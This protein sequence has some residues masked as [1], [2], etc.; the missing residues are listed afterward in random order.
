M[1]VEEGRE[2]WGERGGRGKGR[3]GGRERGR[4]NLTRLPVTLSSRG[5]SFFSALRMSGRVDESCT[6]VE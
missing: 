6:A 3:E 5:D 2:G 1:G 4:E